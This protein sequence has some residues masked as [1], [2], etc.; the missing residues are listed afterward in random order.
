MLYKFTEFEIRFAIYLYNVVCCEKFDALNEEKLSEI[1]Q[2]DSTL[3]IVFENESQLAK[4]AH[5][6][7][8]FDR[9]KPIDIVHE[10][11]TYIFMKTDADYPFR[12]RLK[13]LA[14]QLYV[15]REI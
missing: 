4:I 8:A 3:L 7:P 5:L 1:S 13:E 2:S 12:E 14:K 15:T 10:G 6:I 11:R 9:T